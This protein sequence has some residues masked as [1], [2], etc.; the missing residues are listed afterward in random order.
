MANETAVNAAVEK[1]D[2][3]TFKK[4]VAADAWSVDPGGI[5]S[6]A[7]FEKTMAQIKVEPGWKIVDSK[8]IWLSDA[9]AIHIY[10]WNGKASFMGMTMGD[11]LAS[12]TWVNRGGN[13][14]AVFHQE[15]PA[16][17]PMKK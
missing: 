12:T 5:M 8:V 6:M 7:E 1:H 14:V 4:H 3:A 16:P 10:R 9:A 11:S 17:P 2:A 13:W 15:T